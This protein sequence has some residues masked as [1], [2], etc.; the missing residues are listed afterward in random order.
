MS[1]LTATC[2]RWQ[3]L[4]LSLRPQTDDACITNAVGEVA[5]ALLRLGGSAPGPVLLEALAWH[6]DPTALV[7]EA[8]SDSPATFAW[9]R[10][11]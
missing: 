3:G 9:S 11:R 10:L 4:V 1:T 7:L 2:R 6:E 5:S 8:L